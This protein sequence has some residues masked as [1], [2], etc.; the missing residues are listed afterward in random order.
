M[1]IIGIIIGLVACAHAAIWLFNDPHETA[2]SVVRAQTKE[3]R[4]EQHGPSDPWAR[5]AEPGRWSTGSSCMFISAPE[6]SSELRCVTGA[7]CT[8]GADNDAFMCR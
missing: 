7:V 5:A 2:A 3:P 6:S 4:D 1:R 8:L